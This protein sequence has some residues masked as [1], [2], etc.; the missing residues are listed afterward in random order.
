MLGA[1]GEL[2]WKLTDEALVIRTPPEKPCEHAFVFK[3][4]RK[5]PHS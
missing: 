5:A 1:E 4:V 3:I 2:D